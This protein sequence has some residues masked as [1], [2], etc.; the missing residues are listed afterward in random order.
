MLLLSR[1]SPYGIQSV[2]YF[3]CCCCCCPAIFFFYSE[4][5]VIQ[6]NGN[7]KKGKKKPNHFLYTIGIFFLLYTYTY[8]RTF[9]VQFGYHCAHVAGSQHVDV[10]VY[11]DGGSEPV[12]KWVRTKMCNN[13]ES[14]HS[15]RNS[16][17]A[18][19]CQH[20]NTTPSTSNRHMHSRTI[21]FSLRNDRMPLLDRI[22]RCS[23][24]QW[25]VR[26]CRS[27]QLS[28]ARPTHFPCHIIVMV[29]YFIIY[30]G[31]RHN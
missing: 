21:Y 23:H 14:I 13:N 12:K 18:T 5:N 16:T 9:R 25:W 31:D 30:G 15:L 17:V 28:S 7:N 26:R 2:H 10:C 8:M 1:L 11:A 20:H 6:L 24:I 3:C 19:Q 4:W 27:A 29:I 22:S